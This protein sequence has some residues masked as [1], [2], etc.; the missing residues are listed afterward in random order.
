MGRVLVK[1]GFVLVNQK[2]SHMKFVK[3]SGK[4]KESIMLYTHHTLAKGTLSG[5]MDQLN[6]TPEELKK[7][8]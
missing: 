4:N 3:Q 6:L 2:G 5:I 8:L 1:L 7:L